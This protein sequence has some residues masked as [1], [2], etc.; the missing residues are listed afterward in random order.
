VNKRKYTTYKQEKK[1]NIKATC[2]SSISLKGQSIGIQR[3]DIVIGRIRR[4][5]LMKF[6]VQ[7]CS[8]KTNDDKYLVVEIKRFKK[9]AKDLLVGHGTNLRMVSIKP[10]DTEIIY[11][12]P[13]LIYKPV[14][15]VSHSNI[16][17]FVLD[18]TC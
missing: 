13:M 6:E 3:A 7:S 8:N 18:C 2:H 14:V 16:A 11:I 15:L 9:V 1:V 4:F 10:E 17:S 5:L 12:S